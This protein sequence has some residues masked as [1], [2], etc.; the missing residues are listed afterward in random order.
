MGCGG[1]KAQ[2][3]PRTPFG[4][5]GVVVREGHQNLG[6]LQERSASLQPASGSVSHLRDW[7]LRSRGT[8]LLGASSKHRGPRHGPT[9]TQ[10]P[11]PG[12]GARPDGFS[13]ERAGPDGRGRPSG[14]LWLLSA[15]A[16]RSAAAFALQSAGLS[17]DDQGQGHLNVKFLFMIQY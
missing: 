3:L 6:V 14:G 15:P 16:E 4:A 5:F 1:T 17:A 13:P 2:I 11:K 12:A 8:R 7:V 10:A 9:A